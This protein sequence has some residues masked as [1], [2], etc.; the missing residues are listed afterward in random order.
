MYITVC[1]TDDQ[2]KFDAWNRA[3]KVGALGQPEG[4]NGEGTGSGVSG[5]GHIYTRGWFM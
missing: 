4:Q 2:C 1:E 3:L 5:G